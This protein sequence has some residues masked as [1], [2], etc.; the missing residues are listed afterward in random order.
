MAI[1]ELHNMENVSFY[2]LNLLNFFPYG[3]VICNLA[4]IQ[5]VITTLFFISVI[6]YKAKMREKKMV[7]ITN[8]MH[9]FDSIIEH[10]KLAKGSVFLRMGDLHSRE[11]Q[12][13][14]VQPMRRTLRNLTLILLRT[15]TSPMPLLSLGRLHTLRRME[16]APIWQ[17]TE[18]EWAQFRLSAFLSSESSWSFLAGRSWWSC[19]S[20][21]LMLLLLHGGKVPRAKVS[22]MCCLGTM[23]SLASCHA[24]GLGLWISSP[25]TLGTSIT[26]HCSPSVSDWQQSRRWRTRGWVLESI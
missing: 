4:Y 11:A 26:T 6:L 9:H 1:W 7:N 16:T 10:N 5:T 13:S 21:P 22:L 15:T 3:F 19:M 17:N 20:S 12:L 14:A 23:A 8:C 2:R 24:P 18:P 25:W